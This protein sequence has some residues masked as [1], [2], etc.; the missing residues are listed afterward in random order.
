MA[1]APAKKITEK[2]VTE[3]A[4]TALTLVPEQGGAVATIA[5]LQTNI[6][7]EDMKRPLL[8]VIQALSPEVEELGVSTGQFFATVL[9]MELGKEVFATVLGMKKEYI[10]WNPQR[11]VE[12][13]ILA[14]SSNGITWDEGGE[15]KEFTVKIPNVGQVKWKTGADVANSGLHLFGSSVP[16]NKDSKPAL[17][18]TFN[19]LLFL[20]DQDILPVVISLS[21]SGIDAAKSLNTIC[22][23]S[24]A[25]DPRSLRIKLRIVTKEKDGQDFFGVVP[26]RGGKNDDETFMKMVSLSERFKNFSTDIN[27]DENRERVRKGNFSETNS[28]Y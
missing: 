12:P 24:T 18:E 25:I 15:N 2:P 17:A 6:G 5:P 14:R 21:R 9:G 22:F 28:E 20:H 10:L 26:M 7:L 8:K 27:T 23:G 1:K 3:E 4:S 11:G 16:G 19:Y 13:M